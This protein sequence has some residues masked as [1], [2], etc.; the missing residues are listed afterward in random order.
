MWGAQEIATAMGTSRAQVFENSEESE[1]NPEV[2]QSKK[3]KWRN[4]RRNILQRYDF[5]DSDMSG[6]RRN[7]HGFYFKD[8][9]SNAELCIGCDEQ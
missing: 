1:Q 6:I 3:Q 9:W 8:E 4:V 5:S 7:F 2:T